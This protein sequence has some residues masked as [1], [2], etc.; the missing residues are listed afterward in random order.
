M[1][2]PECGHFPAWT[3]C[4]E[5]D[6]K[7]EDDVPERFTFVLPLPKNV[8]NNRAH[9]MV[10]YR[11]KKRYKRSCTARYPRKWSRPME[12]ARLSATFFVWNLM[13]Q[14]DNL[15]ARLKFPQDWLVERGYILDDHPDCL[16]LGDVRQEIDRS[17]QR[18]EIT[19]EA[20]A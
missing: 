18:V 14:T 13:D 4:W 1:K 15:P 12:R 6:W 9:H 16:T 8:A 7:A 17:D 11:Q 3:R 5:C 20:V 19:L 2:C 10:E